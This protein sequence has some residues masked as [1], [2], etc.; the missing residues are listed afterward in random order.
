M[1]NCCLQ[2]HQQP[3]ITVGPILEADL[4]GASRV[5]R[6]GR[7]QWERLRLLQV[8]TAWRV[9]MEAKGDSDQQGRSWETRYRVCQSLGVGLGEG[10]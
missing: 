4:Q 7:L 2:G 1:Y 8:S 10:L 5:Q 6:G 3:H 9:S